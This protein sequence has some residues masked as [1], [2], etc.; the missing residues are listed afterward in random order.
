M[1]DA[2]KFAVSVY[3]IVFVGVVAAL[4]HQ[5][6]ISPYNLK[7]R[8]PLANGYTYETLYLKQNVDHFGFENDNTYN[9][10]YLVADQFWNHD[11]GPIFF[12]TGNEGDITWF[13]N[14][15]GFMW[16]IAPEFKALLVFAE[17]RYY[18]ESLPYGSESYANSTMLNYLTAEQ[19]LA[20]HAELVHYIKSTVPGAAKSP[21]IVFGG[22]YGGMLAA[23]MRLKYPNLVLGALAASAPIWQFPG[24]SDCSSFYETA[25]SLYYDASQACG[26]NLRLGWYTISEIGEGAAGGLDFLSQTFS[27]CKPLTS[28]YDLFDMMD[29]LANVYV[30][31]AMVDY[32]YPA[33]FLEPLPG[34]P[35]KEFCKNLATPLKEKDLMVALAKSVKMYFNYTG[36]ATC[37]NISQQATGNLGDKGWGY[38]ACTEMVMPTCSNNS[39]MFYNI[40]WDFKDYAAQCKADSGVE[41]RENWISLQYWGKNI[42][43][44]S[45][46]IFSNGLLDPWSGGG[47][48]QS[49]S[50]SLI[51]I[52]IPLGAHHLDLRAQDP[53]DT[54]DV[55]AARE[56]EKNILKDWLYGQ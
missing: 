38:Q 32:P 51:A 45:N 13:C 37:L 33:S 54:A 6:R 42:K 24:L 16:D 25:S 26:D 19:A 43:S 28:K 35:V 4:P 11:N 10:R 18:G 12:Y 15:T 1:V 53:G 30:N 44:A 41:P 5:R 14:N 46:I 39:N 31:L 3:V 22:S 47:V 7:L 56:Q 27:L 40:P 29:W 23:W 50:P 9:Q 49:L 17:H 2:L 21:V 55:R 20:D 52:Q 34:W 36:Q 48:L 8:N